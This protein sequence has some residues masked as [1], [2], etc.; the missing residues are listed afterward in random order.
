MLDSETRTDSNPL[1]ERVLHLFFAR[2]DTYGRELAGGKANT[3]KAQVTPALIQA[4]LDGRLRIGAH[5]TTLDNLC[6][7]GCIDLDHT[8]HDK[9]LSPEERARVRALGPA[10][11]RKGAELGITL[12]LEF[13]KRGGW[14]VWLFCAKPTPAGVLR[15]VLRYLLAECGL[16]FPRA[17]K[18]GGPHRAVE[19]FPGQDDIRAGF[20]NWVYLP[21]FARGAGGR[22]VIVTVQADDTLTPLALEDLL[23]QLQ[24]V[25]PSR[26]QVLAEWQ[27]V[28]DREQ[29]NG[30]AQTQTASEEGGQYSPVLSHL[31]ARCWRFRDALATQRS[32]GLEEPGWFHWCHTLTVAGYE[33]A[34]EEFSRLSAK[35]D[36]RSEERIGKV[37][38]AQANGTAVGPVRCTTFGCGQTEMRQCF[39]GLLWEREGEITN[40][41]LLHLQGSF[42]G[43][44]GSSSQESGENAPWPEPGK[45]PDGLL[46]VRSCSQIVEVVF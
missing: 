22:A 28:R 32:E 27:E 2:L 12:Y 21:Y 20:G 9:P 11:L 46:P 43:F 4:H 16:P 37:Q 41:P 30:H 13:S 5:S 33:Q 44:S 1:A 17:A 18:S 34:A 31:A 39:S 24:R 36:R 38:Q 10:L 3:D 45:I 35:H 8:G 19:L 14:H 29:S 40:T 23:V 7:W 15:L 42:R 26:L 6:Q 25:P